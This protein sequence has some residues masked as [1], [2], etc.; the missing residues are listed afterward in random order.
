MLIEAKRSGLLVVDVQ[1]RLAPAIAGREEVIAACTV[2]IEAAG[3]LGVPVL[4]SEQY[5]KG[6]GPTVEPL[7]SRLDPA[8]I[9]PKTAFAATGEAEIERAVRALDRDTIVICGMEA[10]I[11]VLQSA[12]GIRMMGLNALVVADA[13][14]SRNPWHR[15][16]ALE[17][18]RADGVEIATTEMVL[19]EW[20]ARAGTP[21]FKALSPLIR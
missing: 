4:A 12:L 6:L 1:E 2:L 9:L 21:E 15:D 11:C 13:T 16:L 3:R 20:L 19:F 10:H 17:R 8:T 18:L 7:R 5:P 14:G